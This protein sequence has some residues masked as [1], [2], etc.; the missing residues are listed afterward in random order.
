MRSLSTSIVE[1][2]ADAILTTD[3][4]GTITSWNK[5]AEQIYGYFVA[6]VIGKNISLLTPQEQSDDSLAPREVPYQGVKIQK[7]K[8]GTLLTVLVSVSALRDDRGKNTGLVVIARKI[9][10]DLTERKKA[11]KKLHLVVEA[12]PTGILMVNR[13]GTIL[14]VNAQVEKLFGYTRE[15]LLNK[16]IEIS[17]ARTF[18]RQSFGLHGGVF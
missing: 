15:Q 1:N 10:D 14:L 16:S 6:E 8:D 9:A 2:A 7:C 5:A 11:E 4:A 18:P 17:S 13:A 3:S 12:A